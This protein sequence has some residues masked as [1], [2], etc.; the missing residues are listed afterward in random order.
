MCIFSLS[1]C[2][3]DYMPIKIL[4]H[5]WTFN[6]GL[7]FMKSYFKM[8]IGININNDT[9]DNSWPYTFYYFIVVQCTWTVIVKKIYV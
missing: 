1:M 3:H 4:Y 5:Y 2:L 9:I 8:E 7:I 6:I